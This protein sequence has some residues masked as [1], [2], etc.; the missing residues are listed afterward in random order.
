MDWLLLVA[1]SVSAAAFGHA[2]LRV[3]TTIRRDSDEDWRAQWKA[4]DPRRRK[5]ITQAIRRGEAVL[6]PTDRELALRAIA[7]VEMTRRATRQTELLTWPLL[8]VAF[9]IAVVY[10]GVSTPLLLGFALLLLVFALGT[11]VSERQRRRLRRSAEATRR[12]M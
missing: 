1:L 7:Q 12:L 3:S 8:F 2:A 5:Q 9:A 11:L 6:E 4:L 10:I